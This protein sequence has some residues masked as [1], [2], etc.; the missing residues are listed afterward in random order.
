MLIKEIHLSGIRS[1]KITLVFRKWQK[2][3]V[4]SGSLLHTSIGLVAIGALETVNEEDITGKDAVNA[5][6]A[7]KK[8]LLAS[9]PPGNTG[10]IFKIPVSYHSADPRIK[11]RTQTELS[12]QQFAG[13]KGKLERLDQFSKKGDWTKPVLYAIKENP[14]LHAT[15]IAGLTGF[16][17]EW[18][19]PNIRKLKNLGLTI[20]HEVGYELSPLGKIFVEKIGI[21]N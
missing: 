2:A 21:N 18:L 7:D 6:F 5:G 12:E 3:A 10:T 13:L 15:G 11:L 4:K 19:K 17:K 16:E 8:Q 14:G 1:G 20:S 9:F